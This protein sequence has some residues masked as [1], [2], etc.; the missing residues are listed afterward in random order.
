MRSARCRGTCRSGSPA[1]SD[2]LLFSI[3]SLPLSHHTGFLQEPEK[4]AAATRRVTSS[5]ISQHIQAGI[6]K[7]KKKK[8]IKGPK[9][10]AAKK[11]LMRSSVGAAVVA[12]DTQVRRQHSNSA[13][14]QHCQCLRRK[15]VSTTICSFN[16][17][18]STCQ[19]LLTCML[20]SHNRGH[21]N[22][23]L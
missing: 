6:Q 1:I 2:C 5:S 4:Q 22:K 17:Q 3:I 13:E 15:D 8:E 12:R 10:L 16:M 19:A 20:S 18:T 7:K 21:Q 23:Q 9:S 14:P 11:V